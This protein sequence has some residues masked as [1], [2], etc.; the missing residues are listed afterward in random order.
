M[1]LDSILL[2]F[3]GAAPMGML[4]RIV[5]QAVL[6]T[7]ENYEDFDEVEKE[8]LI[9]KCVMAT[10]QLKTGARQI[11]QEMHIDDRDL[12]ED[13]GILEKV[14]KGEL[15]KIKARE[16]LEAG[17]V[18]DMPLSEEGSWLRISEFNEEK[19]E[20]T[21]VPTYKPF[22]QLIVR[23]NT[24]PHSGN[25]GR[26]GNT[27][28]HCVLKIRGKSRTHTREL[29]YVRLFNDKKCMPLR[30]GKREEWKVRWENGEALKP[31][32]WGEKERISGG[33]VSKQE[34]KN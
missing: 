10:W 22:G 9:E 7:L 8:E 33:R 2:S 27:R 16:W 30:R 14:V 3:H 1:P 28:I 19:N 13:G 24:L 12:I 17:Y 18:V 34:T 15:D 20:V 26:P 21:I 11:H 29:G 32:K 4:Q 31:G 23:H 5:Q 25:Y 6:N